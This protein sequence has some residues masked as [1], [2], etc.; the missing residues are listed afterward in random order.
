MLFLLCSVKSLFF[1][2]WCSVFPN[3]ILLFVWSQNEW[4]C[5]NCQTQRA[6]LGQLGDSGKMPQPSP[7]SAKPETKTTLVTKKAESKTAPTKAEPN[8][9]PAMAEATPVVPKS[10]PTP[11]PIEAA[12]TVS[13]LNAKMEPTSFKMETTVTAAS[14]Q[15]ETE[16][17][18]KPT[19]LK[20]SPV[21]AEKQPLA[22]STGESSIPTMDPM[23]QTVVT[24]KVEVPNTDVPNTVTVG[25]KEEV[26]KMELSV[27]ELPKT[28]DT[29]PDFS[30]VE[31]DAASSEATVVPGP[32][33]GAMAGVIP[34]TE[35]QPELSAPNRI[36]KEV[37]PDENKLTEPTKSLQKIEVQPKSQE[38]QLVLE[39]EPVIAA[40]SKELADKL[41]EKT[42]DI[43]S[44]LE[45]QPVSTENI[46]IKV[47]PKVSA[48][49]NYYCCT[50]KC[51][52]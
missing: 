10:Q 28:E 39:V 46:I 48:L 17:T 16:T 12:P 19:T 14:A 32:P 40:D 35:T 7:T 21:T 31:A 6:L 44:T 23:Q 45:T 24:E 30:K 22:A 11:T 29:K 20:V 8:T 15:I 51:S 36:I 9:T 5:L 1:I 18:I 47:S 4:L 13:T 37:Q 42:V 2:F 27:T 50:D 34:G 41:P 49:D 33:K 38:P 25:E 52:I 26:A 43:T 3:Y